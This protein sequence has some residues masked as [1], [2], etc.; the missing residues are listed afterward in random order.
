[1]GK[2]LELARHAYSKLGDAHLNYTAQGL[3]V[4][5]TTHFHVWHDSFLPVTLCIYIVDMIHM[6]DMTPSYVTWATWATYTSITLYKALRFV[7]W[8]TCTYGMTDSYVWHDSF[9]CISWLIHMC[10]MTRLHVWHHSFIYA[11][12]NT[13]LNYT[14]QSLKVR[15]MNH[16]Y[17]WHHSFI[18]AHNQTGQHISELHRTESWNQRHDSYTRVAWLMQMYALI[19]SYA[20]RDSIIC[21]T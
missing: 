21:L 17:V 10:D 4:R 7:T 5:H 6:C 19:Y 18:Y 3:E 15:G 1:M 11:L 16:L 9:L 13:Y 2:T 14:A 20:W 12:C 8:L